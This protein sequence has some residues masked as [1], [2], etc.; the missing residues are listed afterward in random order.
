MSKV[1]W[2]FGYGSLMWDP[3]FR[4]AETVR[5]R[6]TGY[7]RSFCLRSTRYRGTEETPG[8]VL[9]LDAEQGAECRGLAL[10]IADGEYDEVMHYLRERELD[11]GAYHEA[12]L[13]VALEDG[14]GIEAVAYVMRRDHWQYA[15]NLCARE[16]AEIIARAEGGRGPN[17]DYLFNT[18]RHLAE[19][20]LPDAWLERLSGDVRRLMRNGPGGSA[21]P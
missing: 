17:A 9:G 18:T 5:A 15:G 7:A 19:M 8:L 11:T 13:P 20:G 10:R 2:V 16:Q 3:G 12:I 6:L 21:A 1:F 14:R 4:P